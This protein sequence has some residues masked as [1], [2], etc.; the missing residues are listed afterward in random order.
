MAWTDL[1]RLRDAPRVGAWIAGIA[2]NLATAAARQ[3][4]RLAELDAA[5]SVREAEIVLA[6]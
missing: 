3:R 1:E 4:A 6:R 2:R 5:D